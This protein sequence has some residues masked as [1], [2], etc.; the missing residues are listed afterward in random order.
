M[1]REPV[2]RGAWIHPGTHVDLIGAYKADMREADDDLISSAAL[3][4]DSR[5]TTIHHIGELMMPI[6]SG[7]ITE[8][9]VLGDLYDLAEGS[10]TARLSP[11]EITVFKNGGGAHLD[12]M[13]ASFLS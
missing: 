6:A 11:G 4:V 13:I 9:S 7:A 5:E 12:L 3:Y 8:A 10:A 1:A 2:L